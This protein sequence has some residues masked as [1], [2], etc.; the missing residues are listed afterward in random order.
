MGCERELGESTVLL[1]VHEERLELGE[2]VAKVR[3]TQFFYSFVLYLTVDS[4]GITSF[5]LCGDCG[6]S[7]HP[8]RYVR[9]Y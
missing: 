2:G 3:W 6:W 1:R 4:N 8:S 7:V 5:V 9:P